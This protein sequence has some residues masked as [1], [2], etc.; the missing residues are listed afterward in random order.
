MFSTVRTEYTNLNAMGNQQNGFA[1]QFILDAPA[2]NDA[3]YLSIN[4]T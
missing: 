1:F 2:E 3:S 4:C